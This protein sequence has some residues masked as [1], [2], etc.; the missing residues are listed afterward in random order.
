MTRY[1]NALVILVAAAI[2]ATSISPTFAKPNNG[3]YARSGEA[4]KKAMY[5]DYCAGLKNDLATAEKEADKRAG[6]KEAEK[7][8]KLADGA[9]EMGHAAGCSWAA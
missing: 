5:D 7:W 2:A 9:W 4:F 1:R 3:A 6:T 8:S